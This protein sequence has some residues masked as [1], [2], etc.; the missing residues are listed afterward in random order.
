MN[1]FLITVVC[2][3]F[4]NQ[5]E[6]FETIQSIVRSAVSVEHLIEVVVIDSSCD[7]ISNNNRI[8]LKA[9]F[10][11][12]LSYKYFFVH[13][14]GIFSA[15]NYS[16]EHASGLY[17]NFM[18]SGDVFSE[19]FN[20]S[21]ITSSIS[22]YSVDSSKDSSYPYLFYGR[23]L[24]QSCLNSLNY[25]NPP[26]NVLPHSRY[27]WNYVVP[28]GHQSCF[29]LRSW[30]LLNLYFPRG[31]GSDRPI[32]KRSLSQAVFVD[33]VICYF[34]LSGSSSMNNL[35]PKDYFSYFFAIKSPLVKLGFWPKLLIMILFGDKWEYVRFYRLALL[36][37]L[38][39]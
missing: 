17:V 26:A 4:N 29:F 22:Q 10:P 28:P 34:R 37:F 16:L 25:L 23:T 24:V 11:P 30:H 31:H 27:F 7:P 39:F 36:S 33:T 8:L 1:N 35:K 15:M 19:Q 2:L 21:L 13:P 20:L 12:F 32:I 9:M 6:L 3:T 5:E 14:S 18:N 38:V